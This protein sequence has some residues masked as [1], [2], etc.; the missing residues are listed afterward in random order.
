MA[1]SI[2]RLEGEEQVNTQSQNSQTTPVVTSFS[3]GSWV[4]TWVSEAQDGPGW[5]IYQRRYDSNGASTSG[6]IRINTVT[7][8]KLL[9]PSVTTLKSKDENGYVFDIGWVVTWTSADQ[10]ETEFDIYQQRFDMNG[11]VPEDEQENPLPEQ[12]VNTTTD[13]KQAQAKV[14]GLANGGWVVTWTSQGQDGSGYGIYQQRYNGEGLAVGTEQ[15]VNTSTANDEEQPTVTALN[16]GGWLVTWRSIA[17]NDDSGDLYQQRYDSL[18]NPAGVEQRVNSFTVSDQARPSVVNL[19]PTETNTA[20]G[21][22]VVWNSDGQ[23]GSGEEIFQQQFTQVD[24]FGIGR[25][26]GSGSA[27][28]DTFNVSNGG[29]T[30]GNSVE[31]GFGTDTLRLI[32]AGT[33]DLTKATLSGIEIVQGSGGDDVIITNSLRLAEIVGIRGGAGTDE[34]QLKVGGYDFDRFFISGIEKISLTGSTRVDVSDKATALLLSTDRANA[35]V[36]LAGG[37]FTLAE[38]Q[39]LYNQGFR[40]ISDSNGSHKLQS[41]DPSL[42]KASVQENAGAGTVIGDLSA[43][44]P[45]PKDGLRFELIDNAGGRF[46]LSGNKIVVADGALLDHE[47]AAS[48]TIR[49]RVTDLGGIA[50]EKSFTITVDNISLEEIKGTA[51]ADRLTGGSGKDVLYG[52]VG[53]DTLTGGA[54]ED[55]FAFDTK[56]NTKTNRDTIGDFSVKDDAIWLDNSV[57][58]KLGKAGS[59]AAPAALKNTFF[60]TGS[61]AKDKNDYIIYDKAKG[62]LLYDADGSGKGKAV[63]FATLTKGLALKAS[64][65][66]VI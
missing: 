20:G 30:E 27:D 56:S 66:F 17:Q 60:A 54:G 36:V 40:T 63:E 45:N 43:I 41:M 12:K 1:V 18:G 5:D 24:A 16:D 42:S 13:G 57:F 51:G 38:R 25:E 53:K 33:M 34:L 58:T 32:E 62:V 9:D 8:L 10:T 31:G 15:R 28:H 46:A 61:K 47:T 26:A 65:F 3:D 29:L 35:F 55:I 14:T 39:Q 52:G 64:D 7:G 44:D 2:V 50:S 11:S 19:P 59:I 4:V 23:D 48:H 21:W 22:V 37:V 49:V 6:D